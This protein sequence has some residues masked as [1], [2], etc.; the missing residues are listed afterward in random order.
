[1]VVKTA[2]GAV[3]STTIANSASARDELFE[4][5]IDAVK[6]LGLEIHQPEAGDDVLPVFAPKGLESDEKL[7][8]ASMR[9]ATLFPKL[10]AFVQEA[11]KGTSLNL[12]Q[13]IMSDVPFSA[14]PVVAA[15]QEMRCSQLPTTDFKHAKH[16]IFYMSTSEKFETGEARDLILQAF[17]S[18]WNERLALS[19]EERDELIEYLNILEPESSVHYL[20]VVML[21]V[22]ERVERQ[23]EPDDYFV[24]LS[25]RE[26]VNGGEAAIHI[27]PISPYCFN[28]LQQRAILCWLENRFKCSKYLGSMI[29][30]NIRNAIL[31]W[32]RVVGVTATKR[33]GA[34]EGGHH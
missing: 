3:F 18:A 32:R 9:I 24:I 19:K 21:D 7:L 22:L 28:S 14:P 17:P 15:R 16:A 31:F 26:V 11:K 8:S 6:R 10:T 13:R 20:P 4:V 27:A 34:D 30:N 23:E 25:L 33:S 12:G 29:K 5:T 1:M 2:S